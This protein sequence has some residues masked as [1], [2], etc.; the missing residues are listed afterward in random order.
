M[1]SDSQH[2]IVE[3]TRPAHRDLR[4]FRGFAYEQVIRELARLERE[5]ELGQPLSGNLSGARSLHFTLK[6][7]GQHR[8][9]Y[10]VVTEDRQVLVFAIGS[11]ENFYRE[12]ERRVRSI[13]E[14]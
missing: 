5:P 2:W 1:T 4:R 10:F 6:G 9:A 7:S 11:R 3:L 12:A 14:D 13:L 8:A